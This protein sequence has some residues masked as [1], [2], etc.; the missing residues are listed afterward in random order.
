MSRAF[1]HPVTIWITVGI[2]AALIVALLVIAILSATG[3]VK[4][5]F[6]KELWKRT[7]AWAVMAPIL[8]GPVLLGRPW[9][10]VGVA[11]LSLACYSEFARATGLR[12]SAG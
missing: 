12:G 4:D 9:T 6:R 8:I 3:V 2:G 1:D 7:L 5:P 10:I 11:V